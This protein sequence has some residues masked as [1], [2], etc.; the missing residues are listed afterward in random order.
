MSHDVYKFIGKENMTK[1]K[2]QW[3]VKCYVFYFHLLHRVF[4]NR[5]GQNKIPNFGST[6]LLSWRASCR[7]SWNK[8]TLAALTYILQNLG[9]STVKLISHSGKVQGK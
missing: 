1:R 5:K 6:F 2:P 9:V 4:A 3:V 7:T 8:K